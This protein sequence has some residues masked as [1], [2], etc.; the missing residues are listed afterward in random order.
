MRIVIIGGGELSVKTAQIVIQRGHEVVIVDNSPEKLEYL[1][2]SLDCSFLEGDGGSP[3][4]LEEAGPEHTDVLLCLTDNDQNNIIAGL[5][6]RSLGYSRVIVRI[7]DESFETICHELGLDNLVVPSRTISRYLS[8][9]VEGKTSLELSSM[10][11]D[12]ARL[13]TFVA[14]E[15]DAKKIHNLELPKGAAVI[16][17]YRNEKFNLADPDETI[18]EGDEIVIIC[19][20]DHLEELRD[21]WKPIQSEERHKEEE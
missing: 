17:Y 9:M 7:E 2:E 12:D 4:V 8:D 20:S 3:K 14:T 18:Q 13:F 19:H 6:G 16:C 15:D 5:V 10:I 21:R 11:K 1:S